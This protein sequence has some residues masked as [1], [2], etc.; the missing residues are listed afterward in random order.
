MTQPSAPDVERQEL[1]DWLRH[2]AAIRREGFDDE[3][4]A[5]KFERAADILAAQPSAAEVMRLAE[6]LV[7][8]SIEYR[9]GNG[10]GVYSDQSTVTAARQALAAVASA[11]KET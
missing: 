6:A 8:A 3:N 1:A 7:T 9:C 10:T 2:E 5:T 4:R 11:E